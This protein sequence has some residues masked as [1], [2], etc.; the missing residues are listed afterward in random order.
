MA[1]AAIGTDTSDMVGVHHVFRRAFSSAPQTVATATGDEARRA[2]LKNYYDNVL[3]FLEIHHQGE[4]QLVFGLL[5]E[6]APETSAVVDDMDGQHEAITS[7]IEQ[8]RHALDSWA[9]FGD[10]ASTETASA[11]KALGDRLGEH[12]DEEETEILPLAAKHLSPDE[13]GALPGHAIGHFAGDK[14]WLILGLVRENMTP[15]QRDSMLAHMPPPAREMW[16]TVGED[17][18]NELMAQ[19]R[20]TS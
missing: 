9:H 8:S 16:Q 3:S 2:L 11:L 6:R 19:I 5:R 18:F 17:S 13:W 10:A 1:D 20:Q 14:V 7:S 4:E 15:D 12:L